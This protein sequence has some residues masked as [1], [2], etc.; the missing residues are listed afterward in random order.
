ML[1][2]QSPSSEGEEGERKRKRFPL[3]TMLVALIVLSWRLILIFR[4]GNMMWWILMERIVPYLWI[5][6]SIHRTFLTQSSMFLHVQFFVLISSWLIEWLMIWLI[7]ALGWCGSCGGKYAND[8]RLKIVGS[9]SIFPICAPLD[10]LDMQWSFLS[11]FCLDFS[12][13]WN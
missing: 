4:H 8:W 12:W 5:G 3:L 10:E 6:Q 7:C 13:W 1:D 9:Y 2:F 11:V